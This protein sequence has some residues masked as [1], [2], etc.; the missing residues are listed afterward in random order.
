MNLTSGFAFLN[1]VGVS[2]TQQPMLMRVNP[3][4]PDAS[5]LI[6]K[7]EGGPGITGLRMPRLS[8]ALSQ[9]TIDNIRQWICDGAPDD[10]TGPM[11]R[12]GY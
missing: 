7:L 8:P 11:F 3:G 2:S 12:P 4:N 10:S 1:I 6:R 9:G 5:Y